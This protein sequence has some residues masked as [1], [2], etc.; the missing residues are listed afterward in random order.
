MSHN[1][2]TL[3]SLLVFIYVA[4]SQQLSYVGSRY[5]GRYPVLLLLLLGW[6]C[7]VVVSVLVSINIVN[8][9]WA[10]LVL[11]WVTICGRVNHLGM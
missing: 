1:S 4:L 8:Q 5:L 6:Q 3:G 11:G 9:H 10:W 2:A 7:S